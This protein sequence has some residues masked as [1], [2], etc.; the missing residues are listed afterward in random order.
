MSKLSVIV[1][2][3][4]IAIKPFPVSTRKYIVDKEWPKYYYLSFYIYIKYKKCLS[5]Y[6]I[7]DICWSKPGSIWNV[8]DEWCEANCRGGIH[9]ACDPNN[10]VFQ[11]CTCEDTSSNNT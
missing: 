8:S 9:P 7:I 11:I 3:L 1:L 5:I 10:G 4:F 6:Y 2:V